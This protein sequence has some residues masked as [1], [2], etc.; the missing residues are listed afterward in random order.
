MN[1]Y[2]PKRDATERKW[3]ILDAKGKVLGR[4]AAQAA[5]ILRGKHKPIY[6]PHMECGD[7]V[8]IV[9]AVDARVTGKKLSEK[10]YYFHSGTTGGLKETTY[11]EMMERHPTRAMTL[12]IKGM[13][14][15]NSLGRTL[16]TR[17]RVYPGAEH[18][19]AAQQPV[20]YPLA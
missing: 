11:E 10:K 6:T 18:P 9:N 14:P 5:S 8:I 1:T 16:L 20:V 3:V 17:L 12:A 7:H 19:H 15:K 4:V 13:L 2:V